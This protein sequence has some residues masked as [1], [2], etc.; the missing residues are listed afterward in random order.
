MNTFTPIIISEE[1]VYQNHV[2]P[3]SLRIADRTGSVG[4]M[5]VAAPDREPAASW[6]QLH[7][8][9]R[10]IAFAFAAP[11]AEGYFSPPATPPTATAV[12]GDRIRDACRSGSTPAMSG[13]GNTYFALTGAWAA[14]ISPP[15][16]C[17]CGN[18]LAGTR[19]ATITG[20][21]LVLEKFGSGG[22]GP[23]LPG[24]VFRI[25]PSSQAIR[26]SCLSLGLPAAVHEPHTR[27]HASWRR[28][29]SGPW[30][31]NA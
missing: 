8:Q 22:K 29:N 1:Q 7:R 20:D 11:A 2:F 4:E 16:F 30:P 28:V 13:P 12:A 23:I 3:K 18:T 15:P 25:A 24:S 31:P 26:R 14:T 6:P 5:T 27:Y 10:A 19:A 9:S 21:S 17:A